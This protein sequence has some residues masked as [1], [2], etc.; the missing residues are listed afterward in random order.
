MGKICST[1]TVARG[2][3]MNHGQYRILETIKNGGAVYSKYNCQRLYFKKPNVWIVFSTIEPNKNTLSKD[4]WTILKISNDLT[5][6]T[7]I[8]GGNLTKKKGKRVDSGCDEFSNDEM[9]VNLYV[10]FEDCTLQ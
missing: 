8:A 5:E 4:T 9:T 7:D 2:G 3:Y 10:I 6:L 1:N